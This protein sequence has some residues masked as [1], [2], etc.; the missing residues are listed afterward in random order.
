M[1]RFLRSLFTGLFSCVLFTLGIATVTSSFS[2]SVQSTVYAFENLASVPVSARD[3]V[4]VLL[5]YVDT[6]VCKETKRNS[7]GRYYTHYYPCNDG[8]KW[9]SGYGIALKNDASAFVLGNDH[10][11]VYE[12]CAFVGYLDSDKKPIPKN[13]FVVFTKQFQYDYGLNTE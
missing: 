7:Q 6:T 3:T 8:M 2:Q 9:R 13:Y 10:L 12:Y 4:K 11:Q 5:F 1:K